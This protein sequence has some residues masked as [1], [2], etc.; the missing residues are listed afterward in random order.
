MN[1]T[2]LGKGQGMGY[3]N[4]IPKD[5]Y[6]HSLSA[7]GVKSKTPNLDMMSEKTDFLSILQGK[8]FR[9]DFGL[10]STPQKKGLIRELARKVVDGTNWA[11]EWEKQHL[12][13]QKAWVK[14]EYEIAKE[15][16][17]KLRKKGVDKYNEW[18]QTQQKKLDMD[19][20]RNE[21]D[22]NDDGVQDIKVEELEKANVQIVDSL[23][24]IDLD[25]NGVADHQEE[26]FTNL[27]TLDVPMQP[28]YI[29]ENKD[30][31]SN[32]P[33]TLP[34]P[35]MTGAEPQPEPEPIDIDPMQVEEASE[36]EYE[37]DKIGL[38]IP[39]M[40]G[41]D[42]KPK[43]FGEKVGDFAKK[44]FEAGKR[45]T[46]KGIEKGKAYL[47]Q[48]QAEARELHQIPDAKLKQL[49]ISEGS[50]FMGGLNS[51]E[52]ELIRR[53]KEKKFLAQKLRDVNEGKT[54]S[55]GAGDLFGFLNPVATLTPK[56]AKQVEDKPLIGE[57]LSFLNPL[58]AF[59]P[60]T[61]AVPK[62]E[63]Y[64]DTKLKPSMKRLNNGFKPLGFLNPIDELS[65]ARKR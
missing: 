5:S 28:S 61:K 43:T 19:D 35:T 17:S 22:L 7:K 27:N 42:I 36:V 57:N 4:I 38:P 24:T 65:I 63:R 37:Q 26:G 2:G 44:E 18:R 1:R 8:G 53:E 60:N 13:Q 45:V 21:L 3:K 34:I 32:A 51:Y 48:K 64:Y 33:M 56:R 10:I 49:A 11:I 9:K 12:P 39:F 46:Q 25:K 50:G 62:K 20:V 58:S 47:K 6:I 40:T 41:E 14:K 31:V 16:A 29:E 55:G 23:D 54:S 30:V 15:E 52:K 59:K